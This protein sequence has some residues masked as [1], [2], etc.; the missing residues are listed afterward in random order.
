MATRL[1]FIIALAHISHVRFVVC[2]TGCSG[3]AY[4]VRLL[5]VLPG[6]RILVMSKTAEKLIEFEMGVPVEE[7]CRKADIVFDE[8]DF[9]ASIASGS[10]AF[11]A[12]IVVPCSI[13]TM[14]KIAHG[15]AD[16]LITR[17][18]AVAMKQQ[19][20]LIIVP[21]ETPLSAIMIENELKLAR[22]GVC[23]LPANPG[24][25]HSPQS[26]EDIIDFVV[27]K[28]LDQLGLEHD[29]YKKWE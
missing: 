26:V 15:I 1:R 3:I 27:G 6:E 28:I 18:A 11:D 23:I 21:R 7:V 20:P 16:N 2:L 22:S 13:S 24:F 29:L 4:G 12:M 25:Y 19:R 10:Y 17:G 14:A 9:F 5:E 8:K